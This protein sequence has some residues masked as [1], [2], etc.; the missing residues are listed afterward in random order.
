MTVVAACANLLLPQNLNRFAQECSQLLATRMVEH[1]GSAS[2]ILLRVIDAA[3]VQPRRV[4]SL[5]ALV[6]VHHTHVTIS[7]V[8]L[9]RCNSMPQNLFYNTFC[10]SCINCEQLLQHA[11]LALAVSQPL[12]R[13]IFSVK[14]IANGSLHALLQLSARPQLLQRHNSLIA[15]S[16]VT[17]M[18]MYSQAIIAGSA[19]AA[20]D[21]VQI[22]RGLAPL[23]AAA[24]SLQPAADAAAKL[25]V[26]RAAA[27]SQ[28]LAA[29][30]LLLQL[31]DNIF[32]AAR[33]F[34]DPVALHVNGMCLQLLRAQAGIDDALRSVVVGIL[35]AVHR[36]SCAPPAP[37]ALVHKCRFDASRQVER[38]RCSARP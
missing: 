11:Q 37:A 35:A 8:T 26:M 25:T 16:S 12:Q 28:A 2:A 33:L 9:R 5:V 21:A 22:I 38:V 27:D 31:S 6:Q 4:P 24:M 18:L 34:C 36:S 15:V 17:A 14:A 23:D 30:P 19:A 1:V 32:T 29:A 10:P 7:H 3:A 13:P 20:A